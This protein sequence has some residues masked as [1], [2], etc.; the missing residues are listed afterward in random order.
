M[1]PTLIREWVSF[2]SYICHTGRG[3]G[4]MQMAEISTSPNTDSGDCGKPQVR[5]RQKH[6]SGELF[7]WCQCFDPKERLAGLRMFVLLTT[8]LTQVRAIV[9][10]EGALRLPTTYEYD[11]HPVH[12][13][14]LSVLSREKI[15]KF[16]QK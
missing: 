4:A 1:N 3:E 15:H 16:Q 13:S 6:E 2:L 11:N 9:S 8:A 12:P 5:S 7:R 10:T 14:H